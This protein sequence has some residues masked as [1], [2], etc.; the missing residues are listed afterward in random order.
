[1]NL[2]YAVESPTQTDFVGQLSPEEERRLLLSRRVEEGVPSVGL[3]TF[4]LQLPSGFFESLN[5]PAPQGMVHPF[6]NKIYRRYQWMIAI[7]IG[8]TH[9]LLQKLRTSN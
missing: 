1:M 5:C 4:A 3:T 2:A 6:L 8:V 7:G 9:C